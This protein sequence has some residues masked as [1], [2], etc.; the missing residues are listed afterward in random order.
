MRHQLNL[1]RQVSS[2]YL[3]AFAKSEKS[4][5]RLVTVVLE[6]SPKYRP[7]IETKTKNCNL[8]TLPSEAPQAKEKN[9][10]SMTAFTSPS[11]MPLIAADTARLSGLLS[12]SS[13]TFTKYPALTSH[14]SGFFK[15]FFTVK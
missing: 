14:L 10:S 5:T 11:A 15:V 1:L 7:I 3:G 8:L 6:S 12:L 13:R 2:L 4:P 9:T